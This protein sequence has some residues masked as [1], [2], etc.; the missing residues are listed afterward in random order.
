MQRITLSILDKDNNIKV[1]KS[2]T[3][4]VSL[5]YKGEYQAGDYIQL[6]VAQVPCYLKVRLEDSFE[7][8]LLYLT[9]PK[10]L[11]HIPFG[12]DKR[13]YNSDKAFNGGL[14]FLWARVAEPFEIQPYQNLA[15][16]PYLQSQQQGVYPF[17]SSNI[18]A[19]NIRFAARN[20][21]DGYFDNTAHGSYPYT[22]WSNAQNPQAQLII[23]FGREVI[24]DRATLFLRADFPHDS[25][26]QQVKLCFSNGEYECLN[27]ARTAQ[28]QT[29]I[30]PE[31]KTTAV[32]LTDLI[33][34]DV[35]SSPFT[36]LSQIE[37][38]GK[39]A[40]Q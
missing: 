13:V 10:L 14:H 5:T 39:D 20:A 27:L 35:V 31:Q 37:L 8:C 28:P 30:F 4:F 17:V 29:F 34:G 33:N 32:I 1:A 24:L 15:Y 6:E 19:S 21:V 18:N 23:D 11:F 9:E 25:W 26:W 36:A 40:S 7:S 38:Y 22:S 2:Y 3:D 12:D 16:N